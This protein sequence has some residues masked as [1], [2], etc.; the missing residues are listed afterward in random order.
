MKHL[1]TYYSGMPKESNINFLKDYVATS[2]YLMVSIDIFRNWSN[3][4]S[5]AINKS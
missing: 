4:L 2:K 1:L 3:F 5:S